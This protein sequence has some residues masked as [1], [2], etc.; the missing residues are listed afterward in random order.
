[1][2]F[3]GRRWETGTSAEML[4]E[5]RLVLGGEQSGHIVNRNFSDTGD[6]I[7]SA[8]QVL[9]AM[10]DTGKSLRSLK[11]RHAEIS[12]DIDE[13]SPAQTGPASGLP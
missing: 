11:S 1:M 12:A 7:I 4:D 13:Y 6:G 9:N 3:T 8:L 5:K 10:R 2:S